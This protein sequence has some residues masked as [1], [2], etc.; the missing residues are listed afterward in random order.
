[1]TVD[2]SG[3]AVEVTEISEGEEVF[4]HRLGK[5]L[6]TQELV[7][8]VG[9]GVSYRPA[10]G[11]FV[12]VPPETMEGTVI[13]S[14]DGEEAKLVGLRH[15]EAI[16]EDTFGEGE[17]DGVGSD[18]EGER[19][20]GDG[21][22]AGA[23]AEHA[24]GVAEVGAKLVYEKK[25]KETEAE[26]GADVFF[27]GLDRAELDAGAAER[28]GRSETV[29]LEVLGAKLNVGAEFGFDV[30]L[31]G[32]AMEEGVEIGAKLGLH[33]WNSSTSLRGWC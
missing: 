13:V 22:E 24:N 6:L 15:G 17:D 3:E 21:G 4:E 32:A 20:D 11:G 10:I 2:G 5:V 30:G 33:D 23:A 25:A 8:R 16:E 14:D 28:F 27:V 12:V 31:D 9:D 29:A 7:D 26:G 18:A 1:V 19:G